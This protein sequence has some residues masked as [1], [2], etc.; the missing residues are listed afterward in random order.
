MV[1]EVTEGKV[2]RYKTWYAKFRGEMPRSV[3]G[4]KALFDPLLKCDTFHL[5]I[6][7]L[8]RWYPMRFRS[9]METTVSIG[10]ETPTPTTVLR[11][12]A[13]GAHCGACNHAG[14][15]LTNDYLE[16]LEEGTTV[17][18]VLNK[19]GLRLHKLDAKQN[20]AYRGVQAQAMSVGNRIGRPVCVEGN[21]IAEE[22][23]MMFGNP[24]TVSI[25]RKTDQFKEERCIIEPSIEYEGD[26]DW[27]NE[28]VYNP[29]R[30]PFVRVFSLNAKQYGEVDVRDIRKPNWD[31]SAFD[32]LVLPKVTKDLIQ[33][34]VGANVAELPGDLLSGKNG[35]IV[36]LAA[37]PSGVGKTMTAEVMAEQLGIPIYIMDTRELG[38]EARHI[39]HNLDMI[40]KRASRWNCLLL[41]DEADVFMQ[42][43][44]ND[45]QH[46][47]AVAAFLRSMDSFQGVLFLTTNLQ[48]I[49]DP[50]FAS[51]VTIGLKY[52]PLNEQARASLW[53]KMFANADM[54]LKGGV[55]NLAAQ[56]DMNGREIRNA[57]RL[58]RAVI[59]K[60]VTVEE[61]ADICN[62]RVSATFGDSK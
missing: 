3:T 52:E 21:I 50:A 41:L 60:V 35:G 16:S 38:S 61:M 10:R 45:L 40:F 55:A 17:D 49:I 44:G 37:G 62:H 11:I 28:V 59:G 26:E 7:I 53:D 48:K 27:V 25:P 30:L 19:Q 18:S 47:S 42:E 57:V 14:L 51:R 43:R 1:Q 36:I 6:K 39:E 58:A 8:D 23:R 15:R 22:Q 20:E 24:T 4:A 2:F 31:T 12:S 9:S 33:Q 5:D 46:N 54:T 56:H 32:K 29:N 34:L 13:M